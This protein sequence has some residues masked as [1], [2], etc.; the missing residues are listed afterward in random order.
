MPLPGGYTVGNISGGVFNPAVG[1]AMTAANVAYGDPPGSWS[2]LWLYWIGPLLGTHTVLAVFGVT[3]TGGV[4]A[5]IVFRITNPKEYD[6]TR[7]ETRALRDE[8]STTYY[9]L[10]RRPL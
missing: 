4:A 6:E 10:G 3:S 2:K 9:D 8:S 1:L 7:D 5:A